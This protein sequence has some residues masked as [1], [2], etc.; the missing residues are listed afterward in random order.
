MSTEIRIKKKTVNT[1]LKSYRE[2]KKLT[3]LTAYD[4]PTAYV[5]SEAD[6]DMLL[7][8]DSVGMV[9]LGYENTINVTMEEMKIFTKAVSRGAKRPLIVA[10]MPFLSFNRCV[11]ET[12]K[13][14]GELIQSGATAVK[15]EGASASVLEN[16][17]NLTE[18]GI[19]VMGHIGFTPQYINTLG[20]YNIQ[21]K[22]FEKTLKMLDEAKK[23]EKAG[24]FAIVLEMVPQESAKFITENLNIPTIGIGAGKFCSGQVLVVDDLLGRY[25]NFTPKFAKKYADI[26]SIM[27]DSI[28]KYVLDVENGEFPSENEVFN[29]TDQEFEKLEKY[30]NQNS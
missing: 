17:T 2:G 3:M 16:I 7:V 23:L 28:K 21:G 11:W 9:V 12:L 30:S 29:L 6:V 13:N 25:P 5:A 8:G 26:Q 4:Y 24:V 19:A 22:S 18:N 10:D 1:I 27:L 14:A 20:G 15:I